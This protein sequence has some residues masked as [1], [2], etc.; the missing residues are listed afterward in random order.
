M[1][2]NR[3][4]PEVISM[5]RHRHTVPAFI[6]ALLLGLVTIA[7]VAANTTAQTLPFTQ[8]WTNTNLI[9]VNDSWSGVPGVTGFRG[10]DITTG[11]DRPTNA[12]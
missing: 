8:D 1:A 10:Q 6:A 4:L 11:V 3:V 7:P 9:T 2:S 12:S 5:V